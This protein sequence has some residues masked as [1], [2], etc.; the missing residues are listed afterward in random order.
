M[1]RSFLGLVVLALSTVI[2]AIPALAADYAVNPR[3]ERY[4]RERVV[5]I[6][7]DPTPIAVP[8]AV[9]RLP[10]KFDTDR[11]FSTT[12]PAS[13]L[14]RK[15]SRTIPTAPTGL[16]SATPIP[17][18]PKACSIIDFCTCPIRRALSVAEPRFPKVLVCV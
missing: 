8:A 16:T 13:I 3:Q 14:A 10:F 12:P 1:L 2:S 15:T 17:A 18:I 9:A 11:L 4:V 6:D 5:Q 7:G